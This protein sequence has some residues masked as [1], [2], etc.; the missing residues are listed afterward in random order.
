MG[1]PTEK[2]QAKMELIDHPIFM[3]GV[4]KIGKSTLLSEIEGN[5]FI[6][7]GGGL[8]ALN[9]Y[10]AVVN[11]WSEF[12]VTGK[13]FLEGKHDFRTITIDTIDRLHNLCKGYIMKQRNITHPQD[14]EYGK[15]YDIIKDEFMRPLMK[16]ALSKYGLIMVSHVKEIEVTTR[17]AKITKSIPTLQN[18]I[19]ELVDA[20][21]GIILFYTTEQTKEGTR[22]VIRTKPTE[23]YIAGDRTKRFLEYGDIDIL[24]DGKNWERIERIFKG[25]L[26]R[27]EVAKSE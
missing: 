4:S 7:T 1:L 24:T 5:L 14:L 23:N 18:Y 19:W 12:L 13:E 3:Y 6:N 16:L 11:D 2:R 9:V 27:K 26:T 10:E 8:D 20:M 22:R 25:E 15:G 21:S 17:I